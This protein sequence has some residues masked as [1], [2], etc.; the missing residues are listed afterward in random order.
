MLLINVFIY[1]LLSSKTVYIFTLFHSFIMIKNLFCYVYHYYPSV[2]PY[3][4]PNK[5]KIER[6]KGTMELNTLFK[7]ELDTMIQE[8]SSKKRITSK[9]KK[10]LQY[11][12]N[13]L[14]DNNSL[15]SYIKKIIIPK[16]D[17]VNLE[18]EKNQKVIQQ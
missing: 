4:K 15:L 1:A 14:Q 10:L 16:K 3:R 9:D 8:N 17:I 7:N 13:N 11:T 5:R 6:L 18:D 2:T 12:Y